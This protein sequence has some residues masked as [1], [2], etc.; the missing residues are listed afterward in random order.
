MRPNFISAPNLNTNLNTASPLMSF[1]QTLMNNAQEGLKFN[2]Q[3]RQNVK[4][5]DYRDKVYKNQVNHNQNIEAIQGQKLSNDYITKDKMFN[6]TKRLN[7]WKMSKDNPANS[8][9]KN[10]TQ[11][12]K[13]LSAAG[14]DPDSP[15]GLQFQ[16]A[17]LVKKTLVPTV[18]SNGNT[19]MTP[20]S[21]FMGKDNK[22][23]DNNVLNNVRITK[24]ANDVDGKDVTDLNKSIEIANSIGYA[25]DNWNPGYTGMVDDSVNWALNKIGVD[26]PKTRK[27]NE[28][29]ANLQSVANA[30]RNKSFGAALSGF[31]IEEFAKEFP[32]SNAGDGT[33]I[34]K[35]KVKQDIL[36]NALKNT[37]NT[38]V[39]KYGKERADQYFSGLKNKT[40]QSPQQT[41]SSNNIS[42]EDLL[43]AIRGQ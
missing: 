40:Y 1:G 43:K 39:E 22:T 28:W 20:V 24:N 16:K 35:L 9:T 34:P 3:K 12:Q 42:D 11:I 21:N 31:D 37:Y 6:E 27:Y 19:V 25:H 15:T 4:L 30:A 2:E 23:P 8:I 13:T 32:A 17:M 14:I 5:G 41:S 36:N 33:V 7:D 18:D 26:N 29:V 10:G 38:W